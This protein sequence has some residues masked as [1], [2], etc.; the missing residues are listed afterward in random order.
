[1][2]FK[3]GLKYFLALPLEFRFLAVGGVNTGVSAL[4]VLGLQYLF[5]DLLYPQV[6]MVMG[7]LLSTPFGFLTMKHLVFGSRGNPLREYVCYV[8][9]T[10]LNVG[11]GVCLLS[12]LVNVM[13]V[14]TYFSQA[15]CVFL[16]AVLS[17]VLQKYIVFARKE[18]R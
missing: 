7:C 12:L 3:H 18:R 5:F 16:S 1:M 9:S 11:V 13:K 17:Y 6:I 2:F 8:G 10:L 15:A 4:V 14:N